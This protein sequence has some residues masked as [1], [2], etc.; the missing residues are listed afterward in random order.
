MINQN[1]KIKL[2]IIL[3]IFFIRLIIKFIIIFYLKI[4][5]FMIYNI[6]KILMTN[7][8]SNIII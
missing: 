8:F 6:I 3:I 4:N 7:N 1:F 2:M 5:Y